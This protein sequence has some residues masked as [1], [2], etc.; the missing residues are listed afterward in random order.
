MGWNM[1]GLSKRLA[2]RLAALT[3]AT[4]G[5]SGCVYDMGLGY[6]DDGYAYN[7]YDCDPYAPFDSYY[8]CDSGYGFYNIGFGGGWYDSYWYPGHGYYVFDNR[9]SRYHMRDHHRR[10]WAGRRHE[11]YREHR[12]RGRG[13]DGDRRRGRGYGYN[14]DGTR[15]GVVDQPIAWPEQGGGRRSAR[16]GREPEAT[17]PPPLAGDDDWRDGRR[18]RRGNG[19]GRRRNGQDVLRDNGQ[20]GAAV[21]APQPVA[22]PERPRGGEG[23]GGEGRGGEGRGG[24]R[25]QQPTGNATSQQGGTYQ[26]PAAPRA[27]PPAP[28]A[29]PPAP[30]SEPPAQR[31][32]PAPRSVPDRQP[33]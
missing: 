2:A 23:R 28:R 8:A 4:I 10:Y 32:P 1:A 9:G 30:R 16:P 7:Q 14:S 29:Q 5:L 15:D 13:H 3:V 25:W 18:E 21:P 17:P 22:R 31:T 24:G 6:Y 19:E 11:W 33:D 12:G 20:P 27:Q 26:P